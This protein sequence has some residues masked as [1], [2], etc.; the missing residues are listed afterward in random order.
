MA[1]APG[2]Q[3]E[4]GEAAR[5]GGGGGDEEEEERIGEDANCDYILLAEDYR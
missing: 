1:A 5:S 4:T 3:W 2:G